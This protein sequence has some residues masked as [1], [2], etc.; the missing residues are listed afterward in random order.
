M[1]R[2]VNVLRAHV[3]RLAVAA[4][5][6]LAAELSALALMATA[7]WLIARASEQPPLAALSLAIVGVRG[8][9][10]GRGL[11]RYAE[12]LAS[13]DVALRALATLRVRVYEALVP[14][15]PS[16]VS[17]FRS[18]DLLSR[19][20][21]D[22]ESIQHLV[23]RVIVPAI[24][25]SLVGVAAVLVT[26]VLLPAAGAVLAFGLLVAGV[27]VPVFAAVTGRRAARLLAPA[28]A[29]MAARHVDVL[30]GSADL[31][32]FGADTEA[33]VAAE[34]AARRLADV[35]RRTAVTTAAAG[36]A[37]MLVQGATAAAVTLVAV[38]AAAAGSL[39][40]VLVPVLALVALI[41]F[42]PVLPMV[43][44]AR[45]ALESRAA[46][47]RIAALLDTP[48]PVAEP[49][50][51]RPAP[52][53]GAVV[54]VRDLTVR[55]DADRAP[56]LREVD[57]RL[58]PGRRMAVVGSSGSGKS[59]LIAALMRFVE[60]DRGQIMIDGHDVR[61]YAGADVRA[62]ITGVTQDSWLFHTTVR[63]NLRL[64]APESTEERMRGAL[65]SA[66]LLDWVDSLPRG[67]DTVV[68]EA[69]AQLSGGQRQRLGLARVLLADPG[70]MVLDEPTEG[71]EPETADAVIAD[72]LSQTRGRTVLLATHRLAGLQDV[73]EIIVLDSGRVVQ[74]GRHGELV[75]RPGPYRDLWWAGAPGYGQA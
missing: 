46:A 19:M 62:L 18:S 47:V 13:H 52:G 40:P 4:G 69:G 22:V 64:A 59:T 10:V 39:A 74:R 42:E 3:G 65:R 17:A 71:L 61:D 57:F 31:A 16:G 6:S 48:P 9:A 66:R 55:Y 53:P 73:D 68:G 20:V 63:E 12:R 44:A 8:F 2:V 38:D 49:A 35:E 67:L 29:E 36:A 24:T 33:L 21:A 30:H 75:E 45:H 5:A 25:A 26:A 34:R 15:A 32:V 50:A 14:L 54:E 60:P 23:V 1:G 43:P 56:A 51:P 37:A 70:V 41:S 7:A 28:R 27:L 58:E 72:V 11:F